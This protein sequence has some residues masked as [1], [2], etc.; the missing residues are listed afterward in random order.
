MQEGKGREYKES[1]KVKGRKTRV[2]VGSVE[3][4]HMGRGCQIRGPHAPHG[5][6]DPSHPALRHLSSPEKLTAPVPPHKSSTSHSY[7]L[8]GTH[9][10]TEGTLHLKIPSHRHGQ[11]M[12]L[13]RHQLASMLARAR[14]LQQ[15]GTV[16]CLLSEGVRES[17]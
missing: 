6:P 1:M 2:Q 16:V 11:P 10:H 5:P 4:I 3:Q 13:P 14:E 9:T 15:L 17:Q 8:R 7:P 12:K